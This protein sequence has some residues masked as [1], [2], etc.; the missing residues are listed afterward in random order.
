MDLFGVFKKR[1]D[2]FV[3]QKIYLCAREFFMESSDRGPSHDHVTNVVEPD[4]EDL[5]NFFGDRRFFERTEDERD[6]SP[7][8]IKRAGEHPFPGTFIMVSSC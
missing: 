1:R 7:D 6:H 8:R 2:F 4:H 3:N 5:F